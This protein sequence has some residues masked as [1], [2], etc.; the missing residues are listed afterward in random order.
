MMCLDRE[1][2]TAP[3]THDKGHNSAIMLDAPAPGL[4]ET[5]MF[6]FISDG[7]R[8]GRG[9]GVLDPA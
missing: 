5:D 3:L 9:F 6:G 1:E 8:R 4:N 2:P 7:S